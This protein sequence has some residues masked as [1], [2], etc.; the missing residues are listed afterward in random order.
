MPRKTTEQARAEVRA[1]AKAVLAE[2]GVAGFSVDAVVERSGVAK[3]TIYRHWPSAHHLLVDTAA[4]DEGAMPTPNTGALR[5]DLVEIV[6]TMTSKVDQAGMR[7]RILDLLAA[8]G[9]DPQLEAVRD[10]MLE[11]HLQPLHTVLELAQLRGEIGPSVDLALAAD[12]IQGAMFYRRIL[13]GD[14]LDQERIGRLVDTL[15]AGVSSAS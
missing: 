15:M 7:S 8:S 6:S 11:T 5:S 13:R 14:T 1:A 9:R 12:L 10:E 4:T 3:T 2:R